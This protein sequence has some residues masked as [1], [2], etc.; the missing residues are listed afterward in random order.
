MKNP[1]NGNPHR[2]KLGFIDQLT[3][4]DLDRVAILPWLDKHKMD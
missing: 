1:K 4:I 3:R 2:A